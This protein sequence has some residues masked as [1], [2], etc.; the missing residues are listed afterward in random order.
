MDKKNKIIFTVASAVLFVSMFVCSA[1]ND[2]RVLS[3]ANFVAIVSIELICYLT[4]IAYLLYKHFSAKK[5]AK[6]KR[7][8]RYGATESGIL[9]HTD[10]LPLAKGVLVEVYYGPEK[11]VFKKDKQEISIARNKITGIDC[12]AGKD[13]KGQQLAGAATGKYVLGG[14][15]GA[16]IGSLAATTTYLVVSYTSDNKYKYVILDTAASGMF[17]LKVQKDFKQHDTSAPSSIEL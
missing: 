12:V 2:D 8:T 1:L 9:K 10:G 4:L 5:Q 3:Y 11:I 15:T 16:V 17:A 14:M 13:I 6:K 7:L